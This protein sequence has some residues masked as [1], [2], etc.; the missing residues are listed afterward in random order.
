MAS[1]QKIWEIIHGAVG[2]NSPY[3]VKN[4]TK[5][6]AFIQKNQLTPSKIGYIKV[7]APKAAAPPASFTPFRGTP[8]IPVFHLHY[9]GEIYLLDKAQWGEFSKMIIADSKANIENA[10]ELS[11]EE[12]MLV[13]NMTTFLAK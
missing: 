3:F 8:G 7:T 1:A 6:A 12:G 4:Q 13:G 5:I 11:F 9:K 2:G 10:K